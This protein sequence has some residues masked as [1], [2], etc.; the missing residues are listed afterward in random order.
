MKFKYNESENPPA[1][2]FPVR[3]AHPVNRDQ[4]IDLLAKIDTGSDITCIPE[5]LIAQ[6]VLDKWGEIEVMGFEARSTSV[7]LY[8]IYLELPS[9]KRGY[10]NALAFSADHVLLGRDV[11]NLLHLVFD[12]PNLTLEVTE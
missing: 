8:A 4:S 2:Y 1:P 3:V 11:I 9:G 5:S 10:L 7:P 12:G 6:L